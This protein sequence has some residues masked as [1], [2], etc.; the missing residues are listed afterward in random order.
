[1]ACGAKHLETRPWNTKVRGRVCIHAAQTRTG[2]LDLHN[3]ACNPHD[4]TGL[5]LVVAMEKALNLPFGYWREK[6][7]FGAIIAE[8][9]IYDTATAAEGLARFPDQE[10]FGDFSPGRFV[11]LYR[12]LKPITPVPFKGKQ[13]FFFTN[14]PR[15]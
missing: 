5:K 15:L 6:L 7:P 12:D 8:G 13:G 2:I 10:L 3:E 9:E 4:N 11:H 14:L 1:M